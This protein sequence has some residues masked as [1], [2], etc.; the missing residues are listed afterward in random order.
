VNLQVLYAD[1]RRWGRYRGFFIAVMGWLERHAGFHLYRVFVR[2]LV[3]S[4]PELDARLGISL[5]MALLE[6]L[7]KAAGDPELEMTPE[8]AQDAITRG[9]HCVGAF[10]GDR[11]VAYAWRT[12]TA[13]PHAD[14]LWAR[15]GRPFMYG[16]KAFTR[17]SHRGRHIGP[18]L[19][20]SS[21]AHFLDLDYVGQMDFVEVSNFPSL[22]SQNRK[23]SRPVGYAG[24]VK[25]F[26][27]SV[28][29]RTPPVRKLGFEF[30]RAKIPVSVKGIL[31]AGPALP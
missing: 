29:F 27:R 26:G 8:F 28:P 25:W 9:D 21:D 14:G 1:V 5:R 10:E 24:Y 11:L 16:Y 19:S 31:P 12:V 2:P 30:F 4:N 20:H 3:R 18:S 22:V 15:T 7:L 17:E 6:E 23:G 13:G